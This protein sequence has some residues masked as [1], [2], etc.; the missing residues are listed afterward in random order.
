[1]ARGST[2]VFLNV[3]DIERSLAFY[4]SL[5]FK[6][7]HE[8]KME[9]GSVWYADLDL[10]GAELGLGWIEA[11]DDPEYQK[12]VSTPLGA[13]VVV[14]VTVPDVDRLFQRAVEAGAVIEHAPEDRPYGRVTTIN[15]PD[16]YT[17][18][19]LAEPKARRR[20]K[21]ASGAAKRARKAKAMRGRGRGGGRGGSGRRGRGRGR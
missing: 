1:M 20:P 21:V 13:G 15:D 17:L 8:T 7:T 3:H 16:G 5:G 9:N 6:V 4:K 14:Y 12:W 10:D 19:F 2:S 18:V 11:N